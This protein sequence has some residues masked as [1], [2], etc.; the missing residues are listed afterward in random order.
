MRASRCARAHA[1]P[2]EDR[3]V[4]HRWNRAERPHLENHETRR[5]AR[6][7]LCAVRR[8]STEVFVV[9]WQTGPRF[10]L[11]GDADEVLRMPECP[12][13]GEPVK[14]VRGGFEDD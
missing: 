14:V 2:R 13:P 7:G 3:D 6:C 1:R 12:L 9:P 4:N 8:G 11:A 10:G 5:C